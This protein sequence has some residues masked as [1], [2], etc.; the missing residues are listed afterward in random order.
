MRKQG[1]QVVLY[2]AGVNFGGTWRWNTYPGA[3]VDSEV[4]VYELPIPEVWKDW[5]W[6]TDYPT[7]KNFESVLTMSTRP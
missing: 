5:T 3:R 4:P 2:E 7:T 6:S 1:Y